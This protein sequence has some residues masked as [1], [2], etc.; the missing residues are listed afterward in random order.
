MSFFSIFYSLFTPFAVHAAFEDTGTGARPTVMGG[1][2]VAAGDDVQSLMYNPAGLAALRYR[3]LSSEYS[4]L[5]TGLTDGSNLGQYFMGYGQPIKWGGTIAAGW[6]QFNLDELY[7]ERTLSLG[8]GE[9]ITERVAAG[10]AVKQ[11]HHSF[12]APSIS[13]DDNGNIT[14][15]APSFFSQYGNASTAYSF[16]LGLL[17][18]WTHRY[19][20]GLSIQDVSEPNI[21]LNPN[22]HEIVPKTVRLGVSYKGNR[23]LTLAGG[24]TTRESLAN[25]RDTTW[26]GAAEKWWNLKD[27]TAVGARG[28]LATGSRSFNQMAMGA[29]YRFGLYQID[30]AFVFNLTGVT[31]GNTAGTHRFSLGVRFGGEVPTGALIDGTAK[32]ARKQKVKPEPAPAVI[33]QPE[34]EQAE[35]AVKQMQP[36]VQQQLDPAIRKL[37][38]EVEKAAPAGSTVVIILPP[39]PAPPASEEE[40]TARMMQST[41]PKDLPV[42]APEVPAQAGVVIVT[43]APRP[44][45]A[46][47]PVSAADIEIP[48]RVPKKD[49]RAEISELEELMDILVPVEESK[50]R[51]APPA[52]RKQ[53]PARKRSKAA[54][55]AEMKALLEMENAAKTYQSLIESGVSPEEREEY[56]RKLIGQPA[57]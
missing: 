5:Y 18:R 39:K 54:Y 15:T 30:Y 51:T 27:N 28:S 46:A 38:E 24:L 42:A 7:S 49:V 6:K 43:P 55:E 52:V 47:P 13:V 8:Y 53:K 16:D 12:G 3:E 45:Q 57:N 17:V 22:D 56:L 48:L 31:L 4:R 19:A 25:Q 37:L 35:K 33:E 10:L 29:G 34:K 20:M 50:A 2:Y 11:L 44:S 21:A 41:P 9:W 23:G 36:A 26:T 40:G 1:T 14:N 32:K